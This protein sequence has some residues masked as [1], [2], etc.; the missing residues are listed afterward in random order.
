MK[1]YQI[2]AYSMD[3]GA[4]ER[5]E[6]SLIRTAKKKA[7]EYVHD[8]GY[9]GAIVYDLKYRKIVDEKGWMPESAKPIE[10]R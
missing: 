2:V 6:Y 1:R 5:E 7:N 9:D 8:L 10:T 3:V 4:D